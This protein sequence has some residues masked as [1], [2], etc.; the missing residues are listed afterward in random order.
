M[1]LYFTNE[2]F[3]FD[4]VIDKTTCNKIKKLGQ[5]KWEP[6][7]V[8]TSKGTTDEERRIGKKGDYKPDPKIRISDVYWTTEQWIYDLTFPYMYEANKNAGWNLSIK[9]AESMQ[10]TRYKKGGFY[11]FHKDGSSDHLSAYDNPGNAYMHGHVRKLSMS[12]ILND[13]F[14]GGAFEFA[15][16]AKEGCAI[17]PI[18][19]SGGS[20]IIFPSS[21]EHRVAPVTKGTRYSV[22]TWFVGP[23]FV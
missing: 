8:D 19:A 12:V 5:G 18:E 1:S 20:V 3:I 17:T 9:A 15:S 11:E 6:S 2:W 7:S 14:D 21:I 23:P 13:N 4:K 10:I 16:Y 22:V